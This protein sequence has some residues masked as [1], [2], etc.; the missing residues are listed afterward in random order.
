MRRMVEDLACNDF[1]TLK[2]FVGVEIAGRK[3]KVETKHY[4]SQIGA[5]PHD[6]GRE[7]MQ[8]LSDDTHC[9]GN[10]DNCEIMSSIV[11]VLNHECEDARVVET[12]SHFTRRANRVIIACV[13]TDGEHIPS[14]YFRGPVTN[15]HMLSTVDHSI[16][17]P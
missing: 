1:R 17:R 3:R 14:G 6:D 5:P 16:S 15:K 8:S 11:V 7:D 13:T 12:G 9:S 2:M 4:K 10:V